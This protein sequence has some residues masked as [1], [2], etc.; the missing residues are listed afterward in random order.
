MV[1][2]RGPVVLVLSTTVA[3]GAVVLIAEPAAAASITVN[4]TAETATWT[5]T[6]LGGEPLGQEAIVNVSNDNGLCS[7]RE[8]VEAADTNTAVDGCPAGTPGIDT[9]TIPAGTYTIYDDFMLNEPVAVVGANAGV[10]GHA[11]RGAETVLHMELNPYFNAG[12]GIFRI[13]DPNTAGI[14]EGNG[15]TFDGLLFE[16]TS[17]TAHGDEFGGPT[18]LDAVPAWENAIHGA[19]KGDVPGFVLRNSIVQGMT[20]GVYLGGRGTVIER[21]LFRDNDLF[22]ETFGA[23]NDVY[24]DAVYPTA[25]VLIQDNVFAD[26]ALAGVSFSGGV[27]GGTIT[28]NE[29]FTPGQTGDDAATFFFDSTD[30]T[31]TDNTFVGA[32]GDGRAV[33]VFNMTGMRIAGN[34]ITG[35]GQG[36]RL[37]LVD[38]GLPMNSGITATDN[39]IFGNTVGAFARYLDLTTVG[40]YDLSSNWWG[41]NTGP[42]AVSAT[43]GLPADPIRY[44]DDD[45]GVGDHDV[46]TDAERTKVVV[47]DWL[48]LVCTGPTAPVEVG[49]TAPVSGNVQGM[50]TILTTL[51]SVALQPVMTGAVTGG[52]GSVDAAFTGIPTDGFQDPTPAA[53]QRTGTFTGTTPGTGAFTAAVDNELVPCPVTVAAAPEPTPTPTP[54]PTPPPAPAPDPTPAAGGSPTADSLSRTGADSTGLLQLAAVLLLLGGALSLLR[55]RRTG[56]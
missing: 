49:A 42:G 41:T 15:S 1:A 27:A 44:H 10:P 52:I 32:G 19:Q 23:G 37:S 31:V 53:A 28:R 50:P 17:R 8:A 21:N 9:I 48:T 47:D 30:V 3:L 39:R 4:E 24:A 40:A 38:P 13:D 29:F 54:T 18:A 35:Y 36:L 55:R 14:P 22:P 11:A 12:S 33:Q 5:T 16:G 6:P 20:F 7:L 25:E 46:P 51:S 43:T 26:T 2:R 45:G 34:T 56:H